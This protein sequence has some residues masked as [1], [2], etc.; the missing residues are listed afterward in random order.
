MRE[1][2]DA[3]AR[4]L[5]TEGRLVVEFARDEVVAATCRGSGT[6]HRVGHDP[7]QGW[8]CTCEAGGFR[9]RCAHVLALQLVTAPVRLG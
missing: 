6:F 8:H 1:N 7:E 2:V 5:L 4:R 9:R 3:R